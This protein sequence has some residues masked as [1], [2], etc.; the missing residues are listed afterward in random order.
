MSIDEVEDI[1]AAAV[2]EHKVQA[3]FLDY[4]QVVQAAG[5]NR[6]E[7]ITVVSRR[8]KALAMELD[9][10]MVCLSQL[11]RGMFQPNDPRPR[12][13]DLRGSGTLE[14]EADIVL[15]VHRDDYFHQHEPDYQPDNIAEII[16]A[17]QR[18]GPTR[19]VWLSFLP[20]MMRFDNRANEFEATA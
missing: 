19:S 7:Q 6:T 12:M 17:K 20:Q 10:S 5:E 4:V 13:E 2:H 9:V 8:L 11:N 18:N 3:I 14:D 1:A 15:L 16:I